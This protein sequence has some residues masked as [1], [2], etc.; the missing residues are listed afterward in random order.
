MTV[1]RSQIAVS[2]LYREPKVLKLDMRAS[3]RIAS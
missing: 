3:H 1:A 2:V